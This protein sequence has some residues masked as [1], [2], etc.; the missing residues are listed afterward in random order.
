MDP[1]QLI[2]AGAL[3]IV[4]LL[5][6][7]AISIVGWVVR[8]SHEAQQ[9]CEKRIERILQQHQQFTM[10]IAAENA[11]IIADMRHLIERIEAAIDELLQIKQ[12]E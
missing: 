12:G 11:K 10:S 3:G 4:A 2:D 6:L 8:S 1:K 7:A 5:A 9:E